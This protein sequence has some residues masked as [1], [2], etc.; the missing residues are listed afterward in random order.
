MCCAGDETTLS[1]A[2]ERSS[3]HLSKSNLDNPYLT[4]SEKQDL[5]AR[6][7]L[8]PLQ[9]NSWLVNSR[10]PN[11]LLD[12][13]RAERDTVRSVSPLETVDVGA[14]VVVAETGAVGRIEGVGPVAVWV[15]LADGGNAGYT[16]DQLRDADQVE[17]AV[18]AALGTGKRKQPEAPSTTPAPKK[19]RATPREDA[20]TVMAVAPPET[21]AP[22][23]EAV[24]I[25][26]DAPAPPPPTSL[27][28]PIIIDDD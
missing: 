9:I 7:G 16:A 18:A 13:L 1:A 15:R 3:A 11:G 19:P 10:K 2:P 26:V 17:A 23:S 27:D 25:D 28:K 5:A 12:R 24:P 4:H 8:D 14:R 21:L 6:T 22:G 20:S